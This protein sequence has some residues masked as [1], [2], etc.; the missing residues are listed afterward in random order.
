M[1]LGFPRTPVHAPVHAEPSS[2]GYR[3]DAVQ[4][5]PLTRSLTTFA[6]NAA[7]VKDLRVPPIQRQ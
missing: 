1:A 2:R 3:R 4:A 7:H 6:R 5:H